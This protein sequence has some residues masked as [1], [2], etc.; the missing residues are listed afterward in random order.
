MKESKG[1]WFGIRGSFLLAPIVVIMALGIGVF[2]RTKCWDKK[3]P[4]VTAAAPEAKEFLA[5]PVEKLNKT[6]DVTS[7]VSESSVI[8]EVKP[9]DDQRNATEKDLNRLGLTLKNS[10]RVLVKK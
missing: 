4:T 9:S 1:G 10:V 7:V 2:M 5:E 8:S 6:S 3:I